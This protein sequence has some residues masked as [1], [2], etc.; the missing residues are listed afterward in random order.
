MASS[1][2]TSTDVALVDTRT[3]AGSI[4]L[5]L[6]TDIPYRVFIIKDAY[7]SFGVNALTITT[8]GS[9]T[10]EDG[11]TSKVFFDNFSYITLYGNTQNGVWQILS[12]TQYSQ[13]T[14]SSIVGVS[15]I[16]G[17]YFIG[18]GRYLSNIA[19]STNPGVSSLSSIVSYGISSV[20]AG[21]GVSSLSTIVSFGLSSINLGV[22]ANLSSL[23]TSYG[24]IFIT[25]SI[26]ASNIIVTQATISSLTV[27]GLIFGTGDGYVDFD[28][29]R[30]V[31]V[32]SIQE[33]TG[34][35]YATTAN[36]GSVSTV[37]AVFF[38]GLSNTYDRTVIGEISTATVGAQELL[39]YKGG[40]STDR[41]RIQ[42]TGEFRVESGV[43]TR[44]WPNNLSV[45]PTLYAG[46]TGQVGINT[47]T[48]GTG[49]TLDVVGTA[50]AAIIRT[51]VLSSQQLFVSSIF[52]NTFT[53]DG[54]GL[55][56]IGQGV[57]SLSS[58][59]SYGLSSL[60]VAPG[61]SSLSSIVT[62]GLSSLLLN[63][64]INLS[65]LSTSYGQI[66]NTSTLSTIN[67]AAQIGFISTLS[68]TNINAT[69]TNTGVV[70][71][72]SFSTGTFVTDIIS[73]NAIIT[74][75]ILIGASD[76]I[77]DITGPARAT[78]FSTFY[79]DTSTINATTAT[80][81][82]AFISSLN[83]STVI[84]QLISTQQ[85]NVSSI[86]MGSFGTIVDVTGPLRF[87][88]GS[89]I[90]FYASSIMANGLQLG[91]S[92]NTSIFFDGPSVT[93]DRTT[94]S[95]LSIPA[96]ASNQE[97]L[98]YKGS[99]TVDQI[100]LHT[101][102]NIVL[103]AGVGARTWPV[104]TQGATPSMYFLGTAAPGQSQIGINT[105]PTLASG[106]T[107][108][109]V[110]QQSGGGVI[111]APVISTI[112]FFAS[113]FVTNS[114][115]TIQFFASSFVTNTISTGILN[116][117]SL[118]INQLNVLNLSTNTFTVS[119]LNTNFISS[120]QAT[121]SS[122]IVNAM[123]FGAGD[124][125]VDFG[126]VRSVVVSS[127]QTNTATLVTNQIFTSTISATL[128]PIYYNTIISTVNTGNTMSLPTTASGSYLFITTNTASGSNVFLSLPTIS[129][130]TGALFVIKHRGS[131]GGTNFVNV[132]NTASVLAPSTTTTVV[133]SGTEWMSLGISGVA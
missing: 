6:T 124:G 126:A 81:P 8:Q 88:T 36:I 1:L 12:S 90:N 91:T 3:A 61:L 80:F 25:S 123:Q 68:T 11:S 111:R 72:N 84:A 10:F 35:L 27:D 97:L 9:E 53:G 60:I 101:T 131:T 64:N 87:T 86:Q 28:A 107:L 31:V 18:D 47:A 93:Y 127:I 102:G 56:N 121:F 104:A 106:I 117:S 16:Q 71:A 74:S 19:G 83:A 100:R 128:F 65:T 49:V 15:T 78:T 98:L 82:T 39:L 44:I 130:P 55:S 116:I 7:G 69:T 63:I 108:D 30:S 67:I 2:A 103:E 43:A 85:V 38:A 34:T 132:Q 129:V 94:I 40:G 96:T 24:R 4:Q 73:T 92:P 109:V 46:I 50:G 14:V 48:P 125:F 5:P 13:I 51:N 52:A 75:S 29:V 33:N 45:V 17:G 23:S 122:L 32:S 41:V 95:E 77:L 119:T 70:N 89:T 105:I 58:I 133:Y 22:S 54:S 118:N 62:F 42:T 59:V 120:G 26:T 112:Q 57:S 110:S 115:S 113:S 79:I 114:I 20:N 99:G 76:S 66:F 21:Q 37:N